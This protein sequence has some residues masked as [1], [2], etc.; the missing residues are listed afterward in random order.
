MPENTSRE[1]KFRDEGDSLIENK[2]GEIGGPTG[3]PEPHSGSYKANSWP[4]R[5]RYSGQ[6]S[7]KNNNTTIQHV[8]GQQHPFNEDFSRE[9]LGRKQPLYEPDKDPVPGERFGED[10]EESSGRAGYRT[11][12]LPEE[13]S[14]HGRLNSVNMEGRRPE[15]N[16][17]TGRAFM[18][19]DSL[20]DQGTVNLGWD[21]RTSHGGSPP[22]DD[23]VAEGLNPE[24]EML[25]QPD[26]RPISHDQLVIEV[27]GIYAGLVMVE[28][29]CIDI[30]EKQT[31]A[32]QEK[33][34]SKKIQLK[35]DQ[36][37]SLIALHKQVGAT[38][39][40][41]LPHRSAKRVVN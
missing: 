2:G 8:G 26:T 22:L 17:S 23:C 7:I 14:P 12:P 37:Q 24:P 29:K 28:A 35:N 10:H 31:A 32:A 3:S 27:K 36:W 38:C 34:L 9:H 41:N 5:S 40:Q 21:P 13:S 33:D 6:L 19:Y 30:D 1:D 25:L 16:F 20:K 18:H 11:R 15:Q 39:R 4:D